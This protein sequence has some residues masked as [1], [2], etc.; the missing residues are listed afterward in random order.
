M[1]DPTPGSRFH[2]PAHF[3]DFSHRLS[4]NKCPRT[5]RGLI[6]WWNRGINQNEHAWKGER[7]GDVE[8]TGIYEVPHVL[9]SYE[10]SLSLFKAIKTRSSTRHQG[11]NPSYF[12]RPFLIP[13]G[14]NQHNCMYLYSSPYLHVLQD[15]KALYNPSDCTSTGQDTDISLTQRQRLKDDH[16]SMSLRFFGLSLGI[17]ANDHF[18]WSFELICICLYLDLNPCPLCS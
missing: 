18:K 11:G 6:L 14:S 12:S 5:N 9:T 3:S 7:G 13:W 1:L 2:F 16:L 15:S 10:V 4:R 8:Y 17:G